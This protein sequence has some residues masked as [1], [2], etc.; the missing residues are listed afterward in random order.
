MSPDAVW[1]LPLMLVLLG[2]SGAA[3]ASETALF[4]L[5]PAERSRAGRAVDKLLAQPRDLLMGVLLANLVVNILFFAFADRLS[6]ADGGWWDVGFAVVAL[7]ALIVFGEILPKT[8]G[9]RGR[10]WIAPAMAPV[11]VLLVHMVRPLRIALAR[12]MDLIGRWVDGQ[13]GGEHHLDAEELALVLESTAARGELVGADA[14]LLPEIVELRGMR[15]REIMTPRVD[16]LLLDVAELDRAPAVRAAIQARVSW[17]P[18][19]D[20]GADQ[21]LGRVR[22]RDLLRGPQT[23]TRELLE[24]VVFVPEVASVLD[25]LRI[26][27][28][29]E[30]AEAVVVDE[31]GG[32]AGV[33]TLENVFEEI[34]G[35]LRVEGEERYRAVIPQGEG[36][37]RVAGAM[38]VREWNEAFGHRVVPREFE[39]VGGFVTALLGRIPRTGDRVRWGGLVLEVQEARRRRVQWVDTWAEGKGDALAE[40]GRSAP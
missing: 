13:R 24:P 5:T 37:Y 20:G 36:V 18:V 38:G 2:A 25:L 40:T 9:L 28:A 19:V 29:R 34:L 16:A 32:T 10:H 39:T 21:V 31:W 17:L 4:S 35:D 8:L 23:P 33:V 22:L 12:P 27:R 3:S 7:V 1:V 6:G 15:V 11:L 30:T 14:D 26:L